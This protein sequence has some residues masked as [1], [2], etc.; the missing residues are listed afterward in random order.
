MMNIFFVIFLISVPPQR[1]LDGRRQE[2]KKI[3]F[4]MPCNKENKTSLYRVIN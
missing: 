1:A 3:F 4:R 2:G